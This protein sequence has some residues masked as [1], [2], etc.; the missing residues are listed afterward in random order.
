MKQSNR[1]FVKQV[2]FLTS[3]GHGR[4]G[5]ERRELGLGTKGPTLLVT[6]LCVMRPD[7]DTNEMAIASLHPGV[8]RDLVMENTGWPVRFS[9]GVEETAPP[10]SYE[11]EVLRDLHAR[12]ARVHGTAAQGAS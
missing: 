7:A 12:T 1:T 9:G 3:L 10:T 4:T 11:L 8:T 6:D 5:L 2:D